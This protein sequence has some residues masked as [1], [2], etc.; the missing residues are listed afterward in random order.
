MGGKSEG[1]QKRPGSNQVDGGGLVFQHSTLV[2]LCGA[3]NASRFLGFGARQMSSEADL[4]GLQ[5]SC[6]MGWE[7]R[8]GDGKMVNDATYSFGH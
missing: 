7:D 6:G 2:Y 4:S 1:V 8:A 5:V 3:C